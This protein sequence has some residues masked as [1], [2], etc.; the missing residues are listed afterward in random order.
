[1]DGN[2]SS[3]GMGRRAATYP[4]RRGEFGEQNSE[5]HELISTFSPFLPFHILKKNLLVMHSTF[6]WGKARWV[7]CLVVFLAYNS[8]SLLNRTKRTCLTSV[9]PLKTFTKGWLSL[10]ASCSKSPKIINHTHLLYSLR[11]SSV[12]HSTCRS[13][14]ECVLLGCEK[15]W[16]LIAEPTLEPEVAV[17]HAFVL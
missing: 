14:Q 17:D 3:R 15:D 12:C 5:L 10:N 13:R 16:V 6:P 9:F 4:W 8:C 1:M 2:C 11:E 7:Q